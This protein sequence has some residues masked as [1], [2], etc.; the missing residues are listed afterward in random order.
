[1][2]VIF[3]SEGLI[4]TSECWQKSGHAPLK[5]I[6]GGPLKK[7]EIYE[8][9]QSFKYLKE[10]ATKKFDILELETLLLNHRL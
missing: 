3:L 8:Q 10:S 4:C 7:S 2:L 5:G 1:M 9:V 6:E